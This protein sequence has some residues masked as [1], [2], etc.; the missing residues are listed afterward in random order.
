MAVGGNNDIYGFRSAAGADAAHKRDGKS[1]PAAPSPE[2]GRITF[3]ATAEATS[4]S[5]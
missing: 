2:G 3:E 5:I 1:T 4:K